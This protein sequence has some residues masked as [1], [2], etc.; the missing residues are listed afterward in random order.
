MPTS[1]KGGEN[2]GI[3]VVHH[4]L[5]LYF[6][7]VRGTFA[8][9]PRPPCLTDIGDKPSMLHWLE[10]EIDAIGETKSYRFNTM[11]RATLP[12]GPKGF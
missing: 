3:Y 2:V 1:T 12:L 9:H 8:P 11:S 6:H 10:T 5:I 7:R 4:K